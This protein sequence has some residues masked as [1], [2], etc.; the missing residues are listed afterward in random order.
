MT[1][2]SSVL[3]SS[4]LKGQMVPRLLLLDTRKQLLPFQPFLLLYRSVEDTEEVILSDDSDQDPDFVPEKRRRSTSS[5]EFPPLFKAAQKRKIKSADR[6]ATVSPVKS[7]VQ[8]QTLSWPSASILLSSM[9]SSLPTGEQSL[10]IPRPS[11][12]IYSVPRGRGSAPWRPSTPTSPTSYRR[13]RCS[14]SR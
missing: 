5:S 6:I 4:S 8:P 7:P 9:I 3:L 1:S 11:S 13:G 14:R 10:H 2:L 12:P